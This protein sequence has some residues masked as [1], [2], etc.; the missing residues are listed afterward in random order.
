[1]QASKFGDAELSR[2]A[3]IVNTA[4]TEMTGATSPRLHLELMI[5]RVL[6]PSADATERGALARV[7]RL[8]RRVGVADAV[9]PAPESSRASSASWGAPATPVTRPV[10]STPEP[11][12]PSPAEPGAPGPSEPDFPA[13]V[14]P[15][16]TAPEPPAPSPPTP[17]PEPGPAPAPNPSGP[18][19]PGEVTTQ[20]MRDAWPQIL[21]TVQ[22]TKRSA[23]M[24]VFT[25][26]VRSLDGDVLTLTFPSDNDVMSF[27]QPQQGPNGGV[28]E[29]LRQAIVDVLGIR[30]KFL[31]RSDS[32]RSRPAAVQPAGTTPSEPNGGAA[33]ET[34]PGGP[35]Q[36]VPSGAVPS[37]PEQGRAARVGDAQAGAA[38]IQSSRSARNEPAQG[39]SRSDD[40]VAGASVT[41]WPTVAIPGSKS[42]VAAETSAASG[43]A[44]AT[45]VADRPTA[46]AQPQ[47]EP[48]PEPDPF[49]DVP[50]D[51][52]APPEDPYDDYGYPESALPDG[53]PSGAAS[54]AEA[55]SQA[56]APASQAPAPPAPAA[57]AGP[58]ETRA[59]PGGRAS[60]SAP[61]GRQEQPQ[62]ATSVGFAEPQRYGEAVVREILNATFIEEQP[63][64][65]GQSRY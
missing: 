21:Q 9:A 65:R 47:A 51:E 57:V 35:A 19:Q 61:N 63:V 7:E 29:Y 30:V 24:V 26:R 58:S 34:A 2:C 44:T 54:A 16:A 14:E 39:R 49:A 32:D 36:S 55:A 8:E 23:W 43:A 33:V 22:D 52:D 27:K 6:V 17:T 38:Q 3:D 11:V 25:A 64:Q 60:A 15:P 10:Q 56:A 62:R 53:A 20:Q 40:A 59:D 12:P 13:P 18:S 31:A 45:A 41:S 48:D 5:A 4:L 1:V 46:P 37:G 28:S 50:R 42:A